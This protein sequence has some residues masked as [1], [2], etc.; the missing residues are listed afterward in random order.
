MGKVRHV[1]VA[2]AVWF[3]MLCAAGTAEAKKVPIPCTGESL[4]KVVDIPATEA[5]IGKRVDLGYKFSGCS[6]GDW[7]GYV[8]SSSQYVRLTPEMLNQLLAA[9]NLKEPPEV[10][11][12]LLNGGYGYFWPIMLLIGLVFAI[13][14][15]IVARIVRAEAESVV[16][17]RQGADATPAPQRAPIQSVALDRPVEPRRR[18]TTAVQS[19]PA[20]RSSPPS[21]S[22]SAARPSPRA[23]APPLRTSPQATGFGRRS[24]LR[25]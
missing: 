20:T 15:P 14:R 9:A 19:P 16:H 2:T 1:I 7:V 24:A 22:A 10:P 6:G 18:P 25:A 12:R 3:A 17:G 5:L 4:V 23:S 21:A 11:N 8:G 13:V